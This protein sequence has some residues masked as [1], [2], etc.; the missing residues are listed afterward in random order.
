MQDDLLDVKRTMRQLP[1]KV[2]RN[3][4]ILRSVMSSVSTLETKMDKKIKEYDQRLSELDSRTSDLVGRMEDLEIKVNAMQGS[5]GPPPKEGNQ[6]YANA[7]GSS[8][9]PVPFVTAQPVCDEQVDLVQRFVHIAKEVPLMDEES[10]KEFL[11]SIQY[12]HVKIAKTFLISCSA[13]DTVSQDCA[14]TI[15]LKMKEYPGLADIQLYGITALSLLLYPLYGCPGTIYQRNGK[16]F[17]ESLAANHGI[18]FFISMAERYAGDN[19]IKYNAFGLLA[20]LALARKDCSD[21]IVARNGFKLGM[22]AMVGQPFAQGLVTSVLGIERF[23]FINNFDVNW[24]R[25]PNSIVPAA[26]MLWWTLAMRSFGHRISLTAIGGPQVVE[27]LLM[28]PCPEKCKF[29]LS[30]LQMFL[31]QPLH[32][33]EHQIPAIIPQ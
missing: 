32:P 2:A 19:R 9:E 18:M 20:V 21:E 26:L 23:N 22:I 12:D 6:P 25:D 15:L 5:S 27:A 3:D 11:E 8:Q 31:K 1:E 4:G 33:W 7:L 29:T 10:E 14:Q 28:S 13:P 30:Q 17:A 16:I 24:S